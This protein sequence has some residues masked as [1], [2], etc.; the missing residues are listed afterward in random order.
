[1]K[2]FIE[3]NLRKVFGAK[4][5]EPDPESMSKRKRNEAY[6]AS[7]PPDPHMRDT[8][9][10]SSAEAE[11][12]ARASM[13]KAPVGMTDELAEDHERARNLARAANEKDGSH[14]KSDLV[15]DSERARTE[16]YQANPHEPPQ[17]DL[18]SDTD[19]AREDA[20]RANAPAQKKGKGEE[21]HQDQ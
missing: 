9:A 11:R 5:S 1:M 3:R 10:D 18:A 21:Q 14:L 19:T 4:A 8:L 6:Q 7:V 17:S 16:V 12:N 15:D 2:D 20:E 13:E